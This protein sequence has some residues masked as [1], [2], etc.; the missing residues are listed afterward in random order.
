VRDFAE[1]EFVAKGMLADLEPQLERNESTVAVAPRLGGGH[2]PTSV[3]AG[4][5][6]HRSSLLREQ[7]LSSRAARSDW[8]RSQG[9]HLPGFL[10]DR[11]AEQ[12]RIAGANG[13]EIIAEPTITLEA[14][15]HQNATSRTII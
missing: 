11:V 6:A 13:R 1:R 3:E 12:Q 10:A 7:R 2:Q 9:T 5:H 4:P 15:S 8:A 14:L